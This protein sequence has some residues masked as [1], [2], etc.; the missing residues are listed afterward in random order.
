MMKSGLR[1]IFLKFLH[2]LTM[3]FLLLNLYFWSKFHPYSILTGPQNPKTPHQWE[4]WNLKQWLKFI[5]VTLLLRI[6]LLLPPCYL[7]KACWF[8]LWDLA[9]T[10]W[11]QLAPESFSYI[12][13]LVLETYRPSAVILKAIVVGW[14]EHILPQSYYTADCSRLEHLEGCER[15]RLEERSYS[16][17][18]LVHPMLVGCFYPYFHSWILDP[19]WIK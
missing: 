7:Q 11:H 15:H 4:R 8:S 6:P 19:I 5:F 18:R 16:R 3:L 2:V 17:Q 14:P 12:I 10:G 9:R 13:Q 1:K